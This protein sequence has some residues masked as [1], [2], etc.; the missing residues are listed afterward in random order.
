[1]IA[2]YYC[3]IFFVALLLASTCYASS[4][5][6]FIA[7]VDVVESLSMEQL[8]ASLESTDSELGMLAHYSLRSGIGSVGYR[9]ESYKTARNTEWVQV[10]LGQKYS[11][12]QIV[13]VPCVWR[14]TKTDLRADCFP[15]EFSIFAGDGQETNLVASF[16][17]T[18]NILPRIAP[19]VVDCSAIS[20]SWVRV[21]ASLLTPRSFFGRYSF[22]LSELMVFSG[23]ENIALQQPV[24]IS[25]NTYNEHGAR[26]REYLVDGCVPYLMDASQGDQS[27][28]F[29]SDIGIGDNPELTMDLGAVQT[30]SRIHLHAVELAGSIPQSTPSGFGIPPRFIVE[31]ALDPSFL[32]AV[33]LIEYQMSSV[34]DSEPIIMRRFPETPCRYVRLTTIE[35]Y[36]YIGKEDVGSLIGF[37]E[38]ELFSEGR[39]VALG[40]QVEANFELVSSARSFAALTDGLNLYGEILPVREWLGELA[41]RHDLETLRPVIAAEL[42]RRYTRQ[43]TRLANMYW[44]AILLATGIVLS[45]LI[46]RLIHVKQMARM[47]ERYVADLHDELGANVH[48]IG[49]LG[50]VALASLEKP[51]RLKS[52]L[53]HSRDLTE[54]TGHA[55]RHCINMQ[56]AYGS[57][58]NLRSDL[59]RISLRILADLE[60]EISITG[61]E[62]LEKLK[63]HKSNEVFVFYKECLVNISR[64]SAATSVKTILTAS[65]KSI[66][67]SVSDNGRGLSD[68]SK[69]MVPKSLRRRARLMG[70]QVQVESLEGK[71]TCVTLKLRT[72]RFWII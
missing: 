33:R 53:M 26:K 38:I 51:E 50:D 69:N 7:D 21:E 37:A 11:I 28:A 48:T 58:G 55:I 17:E 54:R 71:G 27:I 5:D 35:P 30:L 40:K 57:R 19:V 61:E 41:R 63:P 43:K 46:E 68:D 64:H 70:A 42:N 47:R 13:L 6:E 3:E 39:N 24:K 49:L 20:A 66:V 12:D 31:G 2:M 18:D 45:I 52:T 10:D 16:S 60:Y 1:M 34:Y 22:E 72:R 44:L 9:S 23:P 56:E 25:S 15:L 65:R 36:I 29:V 4:C 14:D 32:D 59:E 8:E 62:F 67:L